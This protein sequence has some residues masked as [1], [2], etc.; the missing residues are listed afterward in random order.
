MVKQVLIFYEDERIIR[1]ICCYIELKTSNI[2][3]RQRE[4]RKKIP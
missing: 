1:N 4:I 3:I 2:A